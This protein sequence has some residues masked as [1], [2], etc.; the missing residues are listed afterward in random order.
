MNRFKLSLPQVAALVIACVTAAWALTAR[1]QGT[2]QHLETRAMETFVQKDAFS[3][4][5]ERF[6]KVET[7]VEQLKTDMVE[8]KTGVKF[9][10]ERAKDD[11]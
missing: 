7:D 5:K 6:E 11:G 1:L 8:T 9:L 4:F 10:V 2:E 3:E